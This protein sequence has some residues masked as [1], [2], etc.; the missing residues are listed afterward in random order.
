MNVDYHLAHLYN[1]EIGPGLSAGL[2]FFIR[3]ADLKKADVGLIIGLED[4]FFYTSNGFQN[5]AKINL[6]IGVWNN[7]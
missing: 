7:D 5:H 4:S 2:N 3:F 6:S 1:A